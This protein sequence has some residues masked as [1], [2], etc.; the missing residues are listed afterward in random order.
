MTIDDTTV[1]ALLRVLLIE[2]ERRWNVVVSLQLV[3]RSR[4]IVNR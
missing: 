2:F 3:K 4:W 1:T